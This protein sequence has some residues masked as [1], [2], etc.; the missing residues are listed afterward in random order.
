MINIDELREITRKAKEDRSTKLYNYVLENIMREAHSGNSK[1]EIS[2]MIE[3]NSNVAVAK[4]KERLI[5]AGFAISFTYQNS[6]ITLNI[7]WEE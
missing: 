1:I 6:W 7:S 5:R 4:I 2:F 3:D